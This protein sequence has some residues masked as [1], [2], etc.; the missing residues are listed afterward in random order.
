MRS[1]SL[2]S[3]LNNKF[4]GAT[5]ES[6]PSL[7]AETWNSRGP[8]LSALD[9]AHPYQVVIHHAYMQDRHTLQ[10]QFTLCTWRVALLSIGMK[11]HPKDVW[12]GGAIF[13]HIRVACQ[14]STWITCQEP[15]ISWPAQPPRWPRGPWGLPPRGPCGCLLAA[16]GKRMTVQGDDSAEHA[17][18]SVLLGDASQTVRLARLV[19]ASTQGLCSLGGGHD[20][21]DSMHSRPSVRMGMVPTCWTVSHT[22]LP[23]PPPPPLCP[24]SQR[25]WVWPSAWCRW[26]ASGICSSPVY[27]WS[28]HA[29]AW[30]QTWGSQAQ[31]HAGALHGQPGRWGWFSDAP[32]CWRPAPGFQASSWYN[33]SPAG[34]EAMSLLSVASSWAV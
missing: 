18:S 27:G 15:G 4:M 31:C 16:Q 32:C 14:L 22:P 20:N 1:T 13:H 17:Q 34:T 9:W 33:H 23:L 8:P 7:L 6:L 12:Y 26:M 19:V 28:W 25:S 24:L 3:E 21:G 30:W 2:N 11:H 10:V 5:L 29:W